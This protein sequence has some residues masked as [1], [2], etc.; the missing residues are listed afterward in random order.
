MMKGGNQMM[1][2]GV[3]SWPPLVSE[4]LKN[5]TTAPACQRRQHP[6]KLQHNILGD[7]FKTTF[8]SKLT[9]HQSL[10]LFSSRRHYTNKE[11]PSQQPLCDKWPALCQS[12]D[13]V[14][15]SVVTMGPRRHVTSHWT[16]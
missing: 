4:N 12:D 14:S 11:V 6:Q 13:Q 8:H 9:N 5:G 1:I 10:Q 7:S 2:T 15:V 16:V 3:T